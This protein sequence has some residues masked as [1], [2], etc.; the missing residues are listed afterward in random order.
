ML[1]YANGRML[2]KYNNRISLNAQINKKL[3]KEYTETTLLFT[4]FLLRFT[5]KA[6]NRHWGKT[7]IILSYLNLC[8]HHHCSKNTHPTVPQEDLGAFPPL[9][10]SRYFYPPSASVALFL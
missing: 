4:Q 8:N 1:V 6:G 10:C 3:L 5:S 2:N 7:P 9:N